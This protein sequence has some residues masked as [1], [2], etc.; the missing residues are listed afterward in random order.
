MVTTVQRRLAALPDSSPLRAGIP[1]S[2]LD[3][4]ARRIEQSSAADLEHGPWAP[5][6]GVL[7]DIPETA[8]AELDR[9]GT[10]G[11]FYFNS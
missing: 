4:T 5:A 10:T 8:V 2:I 6:I 11:T 3:E 9:G 1:Q 7:S